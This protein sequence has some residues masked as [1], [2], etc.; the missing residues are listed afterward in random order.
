MIELKIRDILFIS[1]F[2]LSI[3]I[4]NI[5]FEYR[6]YLEFKS[7]KRIETEAIVKNQYP[8]FNK[9]RKKYFV[10]KLQSEKFTFITTSWDN[11]I[12]I[13]NRLVRVTI[14]TPKISFWQY[15]KSFYAVSYD[16]KLLRKTTLAYKISQKIEQLHL[17]SQIS[18]FFNAIFLG[19][20][21]SR[22]LRWKISNLGINH[23]VAISGMHL[24][25]IALFIYGILYYPYNFLQNRFFPY[26]NSF[27]DLSSITLGFFIFYLY[28]LGFIP[29]LFRAFFMWIIGVV[30]AIYGFR[31]FSFTNLALVAISLIAIYPK[32]IFSIGFYLSIA[33][34]FYI[35]LFFQYIK[36]GKI[37][38]YILLNIMLFVWFLPIGIYFFE[39]AYYIA[40]ISILITLIFPLFYALEILLHFINFDILDNLILTLLNIKVEYRE[41]NLDTSLFLL[42]ILVS[43]TAIKSRFSF[44]L[45]N[46][47]SIT[48]LLYIYLY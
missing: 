41:M 43:L 34:V 40:P 2:F 31:I 26:R 42:Y 35:F 36:I 27:V 47:S 45:L 44:Y 10:L 13:K 23:L 32:A 3:L 39:K 12:D 29:S 18:E 7:T 30:L 20:G 38:S 24:S 1:L 4:I 33:G 37:K 9:N 46:L 8:K 11:L 28:T 19:F 16:I 5:L 15:L 48:F 22:E 14:M 21:I 25:L 17:D 6:A